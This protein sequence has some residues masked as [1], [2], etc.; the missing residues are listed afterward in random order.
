MD[1]RIR[2]A[3]DAM[4]GD[5]GPSIA[6]PGAALSLVRHPDTEFLIF[7]NEK[8]I[9]PHLDAHP[10]LARSSRVIHTEVAISMDAKPSQA[11]RQGAASPA[12]GWLWKQPKRARPMRWFPLAILAR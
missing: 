4:G 11:L 2:I 3:L 8:A 9:E 10:Q 12:C 5:H 1:D 6:I 7:G